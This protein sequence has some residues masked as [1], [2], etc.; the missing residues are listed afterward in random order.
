MENNL[1]HP[2]AMP[3]ATNSHDSRETRNKCALWAFRAIAHKMCNGN[4]NS[5]YKVL[6]DACNDMIGKTDFDEF[7]FLRYAP[8]F[9]IN[10]NDIIKVDN[11]SIIADNQ[12]CQANREPSR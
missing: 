10:P 4:P 11:D 8:Q 9:G 5:P 6:F 1:Q 12:F 3:E 7:D 2:Q